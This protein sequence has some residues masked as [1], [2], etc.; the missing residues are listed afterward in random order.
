MALEYNTVSNHHQKNRGPQ[1]RRSS[2]PA[3]DAAKR[4][5]S[6]AATPFGS[7]TVSYSDTYNYDQY[8]NMSWLPGGSGPV[9]TYLGSSNHIYQIGS[10]Y[11]GYDAA[12]DLTSDGTNTYQYNAEG[13]LSSINGGSTAT[14][15]YNALGER[16]YWPNSGN[17]SYWYD[18]EGNSLGGSWGPNWN[19]FLWFDGRELADY[20]WDGGHFSHAN[21]LNSTTQTTDWAGGGVQETMF[22]PWGQ[23]WS[24][25]PGYFAHEVFAGIKDADPSLGVD[26]ALYRRYQPLLGRW[27]TPD[28]MGGDVTNP[29]SL[30]RYAYVLNNPTTLT[31]PLGLDGGDCSDYEYFISHAECGGTPGCI[32]EGSEGCIPYPPGYPWGGGGG[33]GGGGAPAPPGAPPAGQPPLG[34]AEAFNGILPCIEPLSEIPGIALAAG[35]ALGTT[36]SPGNVQ[37]AAVPVGSGGENEFSIPP[38]NVD[39]GQIAN[40]TSAGADP[41]HSQKWQILVTEPKSIVPS[42]GRV[43]HV[44][45]DA[46]PGAGGQVNIYNIEAHVDIYSPL[47][48]SQNL[49]PG[50]AAGHLAVD[51][52]FYTALEFLRKL[53]GF[54]PC[55]YKFD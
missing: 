37:P 22:Y 28:P 31:D 34:G 48:A 23:I 9:L 8:G 18:P 13:R 45:F 29:Q 4:L 33:G 47:N 3:C 16:V 12:G 39:I 35:G 20:E 54:R 32:A 52:G 50:G 19:A 25:T 46:R 6:A 15:Q 11:A 43:I 7:G 10:L 49:N 24:Q 51:V 2:L 26:Q 44:L 14:F 41:F 17:L 38:M 1:T 36:L 42:P 30:N 27:M 40:A 21:A 53:A 55:G 5:A